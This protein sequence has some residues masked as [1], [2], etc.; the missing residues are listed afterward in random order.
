M[1]HINQIASSFYPE[2][3]YTVSEK[4][5]SVESQPSEI[6]TKLPNL[7]SVRAFRPIMVNPDY[8]GYY[9]SKPRVHNRFIG[10]RSKKIKSFRKYQPRKKYGQL[11]KYKKITRSPSS[12]NDQVVFL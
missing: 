11:Y 3:P 8:T 9:R 12:S 7:E 5:E 2:L 1:T 6:L 4:Y 10:R